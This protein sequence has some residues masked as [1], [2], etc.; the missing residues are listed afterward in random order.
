VIT[1]TKL[2]PVP[3]GVA[4]SPEYP[5]CL[6][7]KYISTNNSDYDENLLRKWLWTCIH[8]HSECLTYQQKA[9]TAEERPT[10][11]LQ[12]GQDYVQ[13]CQTAATDSQYLYATLSHIWGTDPS[14]QLTLTKNNVVELQGGVPITC[15]PKI[16]REAA[17]L[18]RLLGLHYLWID[19]MCIM[20]DSQSDWKHE[21]N[22]MA[23]IYS[24]AAC[25][26]AH[27]FPP[28]HTGL[29]YENPKTFLPCVLRTATE[30]DP[31]LYVA[32]SISVRTPILDHHNWRNTSQWPLSSRAWILQ[33]Q[34]LSPRT[35][36]FGH[37]NL[38][39]E[40]AMETF[41]EHL[42]RVFVDAP[43]KWTLY[44]MV[45]SP[46]CMVDW[47]TI[48]N[49]YR[50][51]QLTQARDRLTA[52]A[53][54]A[55]AAHEMTGMTYLAGLWSERLVESLLWSIRRDFSKGGC[56]E[57]ILEAVVN[58]VP[59][60]SWF[61]VP[62]DFQSTFAFPFVRQK[63]SPFQTQSVVYTSVLLSFQWPSCQQ[64]KLPKYSYQ[65]FEGLQIQV[66]TQTV[67]SELVW[68]ETVTLGAEIVE[69][70]KAQHFVSNVDVYISIDLNHAADN[71]PSTV[72][73]AA[74]TEVQA[75]QTIGLG[76]RSSRRVLAGLILIPGDGMNTW[77]RV[78]MW[79][80]TVTS[81]AGH[82]SGEETPS[83]LSLLDSVR[84]EDI[85]LV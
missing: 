78:G 6:F 80:L 43:S 61:S 85:T 64:N 40:C 58:T 29:S 65:N 24:N 82:N 72:L 19:S 57:D 51:R 20:Q 60:W 28:N 1:L 21:A 12:V 76:P 48:I 11:I 3:V 56:D 5:A 26:L 27:P 7:S 30:S 22:K 59:S 35:I 73:L 47:E 63:S 15:L 4:L 45:Q 84:E 13:L 41:D 54:I 18:T 37:H 8:D 14:Y 75:I 52:F 53:G 9:T 33:E 17:T 46:D 79:I 2:I 16:F 83:F 68:E 66:S 71:V 23:S 81:V 77:K 36:F 70:L 69:K 50:S 67:A 62:I 31:G 10:R 49:H 39:W 32:S 34:L 38:M 55:R 25:N 42:S 44:N 74:L